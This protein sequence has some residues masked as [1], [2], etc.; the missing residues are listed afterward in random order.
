MT[1]P[2][3]HGPETSDGAG[4]DACDRFTSPCPWVCT[5]QILLFGQAWYLPIL[6]WQLL[7]PA[8]LNGASTCRGHLAGS[9]LA[10]YLH[11]RAGFTLQAHVPSSD[12][13]LLCGRGEG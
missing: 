6:V 12:V 5:E 8:W 2:A 9:S 10:V 11:V 13:F 1:G 7:G 4:K 3:A